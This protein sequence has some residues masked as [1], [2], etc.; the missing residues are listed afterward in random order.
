RPGSTPQAANARTM[1]DGKA[2]AKLAQA[3]TPVEPVTMAAG[4][5]GQCHVDSRVNA[6][7]RV[8]INGRYVGT[9]A[10]YG[11]IYP[12]VGDPAGGVTRLYAVSTCGRYS[13][14]RNVYGAFSSYHWILLP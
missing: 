13:W 2:T 3:R 8:Y 5:T 9:M 11:D 12:W 6:W 7:V 14:S 1:N 4:I 10:P